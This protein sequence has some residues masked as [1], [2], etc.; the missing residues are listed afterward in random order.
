MGEFIKKIGKVLLFTGSALL[1]LL[2]C[3]I[4]SRY[5]YPTSMAHFV[6]CDG[7][8]VDMLVPDPEL[9]FKL[10]PNFRGKQV[11]TEFSVSVR[12]DS[13]GFRNDQEFHREKTPGTYRI[14][15]LGD[16][17]AFG[18]GVEENQTYLN[19]LARR[20]E[21]QFGQKVEVMNL[22]VWGYG[23]LQEIEVFHRFKSYHPDLI[24][25]EFYA[26]NAFVPESGN[27]LVDNYYFDVWLKSPR[28]ADIPLPLVR[29]VGR[30]LLFHSNVFRIGA[31]E[32]ATI[33][34]KH[35]QPTGN[36]E[37][38]EA[39][40]QITDNA[41]RRFDRDLQSINKKC[42]LIWAAP[43][44]TI[45][46]RDDFVFRHL[47]SLGLRNIVLASTLPEME[48]EVMNYYY[49]LDFHW[50]A[51]G[52]QAAADVLFQTIVSQGLARPSDPTLDQLGG[53]RRNSPG[54]RDDDAAESQQ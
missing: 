28:N 11:A 7:K 24:T 46:A 26:R 5:L 13:S 19:V 6:E 9:Q 30:F 29:L 43:P 12:T 15:G 3:E 35:W 23:T 22:A 10:K 31:L 1:T 20:L 49:R 36:A 39:A 33:L 45:H 42:V 37:M 25:L 21:Q 47:Q 48:H 38:L 27:D 32:V 34:K 16:S 53:P 8:L 2:L 40:W 18:W 17:F 50:N 41:L 52:Q 44:G 4:A 51:K 54:S 14:L